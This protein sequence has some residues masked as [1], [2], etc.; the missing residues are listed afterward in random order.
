L[1]QIAELCHETAPFGHS[2]EP[3]GMGKLGDGVIVAFPR[4]L[5]LILTGDGPCLIVVIDAHEGK[6]QSSD[7]GQRQLRTGDQGGNLRPDRPGVG[8]HARR[9]IGEQRLASECRY[10][11]ASKNSRRRQA[12]ARPAGTWLACQSGLLFRLSGHG[13]FDQF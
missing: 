7:R 11:G 12:A 8:R 10:C 6:S 13:A 5:A 9:D 4:L 1:E 3:I 2:S